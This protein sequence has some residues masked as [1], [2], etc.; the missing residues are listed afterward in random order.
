MR[1]VEPQMNLTLKSSKK[2]QK[3]AGGEI[4]ENWVGDYRPPTLRVETVQR[5][6]GCPSHYSGLW[7]K[8]PCG[9]WVAA[10]P[11]WQPIEFITIIAAPH[12]AKLT[13]KDNTVVIC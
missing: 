12:Y 10:A 3:A 6:K 1:I 9:R 13:L 11:L 7:V 4:T 8:T 2:K 5:A